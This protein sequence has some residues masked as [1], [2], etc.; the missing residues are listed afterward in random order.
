LVGKGPLEKVRKLKIPGN[1]KRD[2]HVVVSVQ[3]KTT[4]KEEKRNTFL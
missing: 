3:K 2:V 1:N 4:K